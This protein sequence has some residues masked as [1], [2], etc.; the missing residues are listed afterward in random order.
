MARRHRA[1]AALLA[2]VALLLACSAPAARAAASPINADDGVSA[3]EAAEYTRQAQAVAAKAARA[4]ALA[5][6]AGGHPGRTAGEALAAEQGREAQAIKLARGPLAPGGTRTAGEAAAR[7]DAAEQAALACAAEWHE[8]GREEERGELLTVSCELG[9][10]HAFCF[11]GYVSEELMTPQAEEGAEAEEPE[12]VAIFRCRRSEDLGAAASACAAPSGQWTRSSTGGVG[13]SAAFSAAATD[14]P[15]AALAA[16]Q[17][18]AAQAA[19]MRA[20]LLDVA[21]LSGLAELAGDAPADGFGQAFGAL[22]GDD[23][24]AGMTFGMA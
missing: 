19:R 6:A 12:E 8:C 17:K 10:E 7:S 5:A 14:D 11:E 1:A 3:D 13:H 2:A 21:R 18:I 22:L 24:A 9:D 23:G 4:E 15:E 16:Y 20:S